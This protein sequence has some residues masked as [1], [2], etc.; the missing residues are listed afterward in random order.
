MERV[1]IKTKL[2]GLLM[3][4]LR[5]DQ[6]NQGQCKRYV[7]FVETRGIFLHDR[8]LNRR[9]NPREFTKELKTLY[10]QG[11]YEDKYNLYILRKN[12]DKLEEQINRLNGNISKINTELWERLA[13]FMPSKLM[14]NV[15][16][17][18]YGG[19]RDFGFVLIP[20]YVYLNIGNFL[21]N[22]ESI[23]IDVI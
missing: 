2:I 3:E 21:D 10:A 7:R 6:F 22:F 13:Q 1:K 20:R 8:M 18:L 9:S 19:G 14:G 15:N 17:I 16:V 11:D 4:L 5:C 12:L 23:L